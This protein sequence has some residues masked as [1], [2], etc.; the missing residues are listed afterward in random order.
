MKTIADPSSNQSQAKALL[1]DIHASPST[2]LPRRDT[3]VEWL[4]TLVLRSHQKGYVASDEDSKDLIALA[5][6]LR[7]NDVPMAAAAVV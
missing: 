6:F 1:A 7:V 5:R 2:A 4:D 3:L